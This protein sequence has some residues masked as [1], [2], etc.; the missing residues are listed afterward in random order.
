MSTCSL[1]EFS[2][3]VESSILIV[4]DDPAMVQTLAATL[5]GPWKLRFATNGSAAL[6]L[7]D[8]DNPD[9]V[10][11]DADMPGMDGFEVLKRIKGSPHLIDLPVIMVTGLTSEAHERSGLKLGAADFIAKPIRPAVVLARVHTQLNLKRIN[12]QLKAL[13]RADRQNLDSALVELKSRNELLHETSA[14]LQLANEALLQFIR[15]ASHDLREPLNTVTQFS[16]LVIEDP[17]CGL[18][19]LGIQHLQRVVRAGKRMKTLLDDVAAYARLVS[20]DQVE[21]HC[22]DLN[23]VLEE[24]KNSLEREH[25]TSTLTLE[26]ADMPFVRGSREKLSQAISNILLNAQRYA[27]PERSASVRIWAEAT[28]GKV[29]VLFKDNGIGIDPQYWQLVFEPFKKLHR[30][31]AGAG[32]GLGLAISR[33][34]VESLGGSLTLLHSTE[35]GSTFC[36]VLKTSALDK[37]S[38]TASEA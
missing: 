1:G 22:V 16:D 6:R 25:E 14:R 38:T 21:E 26:H 13:S 31:E 8:H 28:N 35:Q 29:N 30:R 7:I 34:I 11:L 19:P 4:D 10:L 37:A 32:N 23:H 5:Q 36:M 27:H 33:R 18:N 9:L 20:E 15:A 3:P 17:S 24:A 12:D 2:Q